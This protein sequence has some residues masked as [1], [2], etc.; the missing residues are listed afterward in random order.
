MRKNEEYAKWARAIIKDMRK[1]H[2][3]WDDMASNYH[4]EQ[5][6]RTAFSHCADALEAMINRN[7]WI[8]SSSDSQ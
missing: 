7:K 8:N 4:F 2:K 1:M 3:D 5:S 6:A